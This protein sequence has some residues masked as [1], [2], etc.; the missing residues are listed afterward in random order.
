M[1][2]VRM[3][4]AGLLSAWTFQGAATA[5]PLSFIA[6][7]PQSAAYFDVSVN[8]SPS[9]PPIVPPDPVHDLTDPTRSRFTQDV[10][11]EALFTFAMQG[12]NG[13]TF[14]FNPIVDPPVVDTPL[15]HLLHFGATGNM[16]SFFD[17]FFSAWYMEEGDMRIPFSGVQV[18]SPTD[19]CQILYT[20]LELEDPPFTVEI[21]VLNPD[22]QNTDPFT[23]R[24]VPEP[25]SLALVSIGAL[26]V[27]L[28]RRRKQRTTLRA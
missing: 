23:F 8:L 10:V 5:A 14:E 26:G 2:V 12:Q 22:G 25:G 17:V 7:D 20:L 16:G 19:P 21:F 15:T 27:G 28:Y 11:N 4:L 6:F 1:R 24:A 13:E 18:S 9:P 3:L